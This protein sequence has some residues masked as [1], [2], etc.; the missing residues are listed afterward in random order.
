[1]HNPQNWLRQTPHQS[2]RWGQSV[3]LPQAGADK[4]D[5]LVVYDNLSASLETRV[6]RDRRVLFL[7]EPPQGIRYRPRYLSQFGIIISPYP[8]TVPDARVILSHAALPWFAGLG[9]DKNGVNINLDFEALEALRP[10]VASL[11]RLSVVT[12][13]KSN[14]PQQRKRLALI[15][16]LK[17]ELGD[18]LVVFGRGVRPVNDKMDAIYGMDFHLVLE[19]NLEPH[20]WTEK[21]ADAFLGWAHPIYVGAPRAPD[22]F[23]SGAMTPIDISDVT[24]AA[25]IITA[26]L[27]QGLS[28]QDRIILA[29]ARHKLMFEH[30]L[31]AML[32]RL[33]ADRP[34]M[35]LLE[36]PETILPDARPNGNSRWKRTGKWLRGLRFWKRKHV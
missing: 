10:P 14:L 2:G 21:L 26:R 24:S 19:N 4:A 29:E 30:N 35:P 22:D 3:I 20:F 9:F 31:F 7:T 5:L 18:D 33:A 23:P 11:P 32:D 8:I 17:D 25:K 34:A 16:A 15:K 27:R 6:P 13:R 36:H 12:S 1:M 28:A